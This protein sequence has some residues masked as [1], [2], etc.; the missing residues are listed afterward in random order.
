MPTEISQRSFLFSIL[1]LFYNADLLEIEN[2]S[3]LVTEYIDDTNII[4]ERNIT[5]SISSKLE[6]LYYKAEL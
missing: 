4:I 6:M 1:F 5:E 2:T 3:I